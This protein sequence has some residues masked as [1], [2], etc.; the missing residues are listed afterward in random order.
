[1]KVCIFEK[2]TSDRASDCK[3]S[4]IRLPESEEH[5]PAPPCLDRGQQVLTRKRTWIRP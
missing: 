4:K 3:S 1:M 2:G 5:P